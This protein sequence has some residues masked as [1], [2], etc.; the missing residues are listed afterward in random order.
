MTGEPTRTTY[1]A[2]RTHYCLKN[3]VAIMLVASCV[4][5]ITNQYKVTMQSK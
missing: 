1:N 3:K 5:P 2:S 4:Q